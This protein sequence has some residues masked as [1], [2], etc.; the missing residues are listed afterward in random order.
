MGSGVGADALENAALA[1]DHEGDCEPRERRVGAA[2]ADQPDEQMVGQLEAIGV[3]R[4]HR[5]EEQEQHRR[6]DEDEDRRLAVAPEQPLLVA[7]LVAEELH[8]F[9]VPL[10]IRSR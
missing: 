2:V 10:S 5:A 8:A 3:A 7:Q 6:E 9:S 4:V 1:A